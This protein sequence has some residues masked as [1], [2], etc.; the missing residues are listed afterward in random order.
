MYSGS[1]P[2]TSQPGG[3]VH[4]VRSVIARAGRRVALPVALAALSGC[5]SV[6]ASVNPVTWW[7]E[8]QGG[9]IAEQRPPPPGATDPYPNIASVPDRPAPL[10]PNIRRTIDQGLVADRANAQHEAAAAPIPDPSSREA[11][12]GLFGA[13]SPPSAAPSSI[14]AKAT[15]PAARPAPAAETAQGPSATLAAASAPPAPAPSVPPALGPR[16]SGEPAEAVP[17]GQLAE[18]STAQMG[19]LPPLPTTPPAPADLPGAN[20]PPPAPARPSPPPPPSG[21]PCG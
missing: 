6:P 18:G 15:S 11:S 19:P 5:G 4:N 13:A 10:D 12:P 8:L 21:D 7:H 16:A 20:P 1:E 17:L 2:E 14:P 9:Q 3:S